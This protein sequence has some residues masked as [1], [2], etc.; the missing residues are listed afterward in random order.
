VRIFGKRRHG[1]PPAQDSPDGR[2][3]A[4]R[5]N[6]SPAASLQVASALA[7]TG[8]WRLVADSY[9]ARRRLVS[10]LLIAAQL[11]RLLSPVK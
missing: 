10:R 8:A 1:N 5:Y 6:H 7:R 11:P 9:W 4:G 3:R 2:R